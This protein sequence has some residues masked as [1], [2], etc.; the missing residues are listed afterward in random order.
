MHIFL[1]FTLDGG[2]FPKPYPSPPPPPQDKMTLHIEQD[3]AWAPEP[4]WMIL[5]GGKSLAAV[6][7]H[8][9]YTNY[10]ILAPILYTGYYKLSL[11]M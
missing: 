8:S 7:K 1:T 9:H 4:V 11:L 5:R 10:A 6:N 3:A 2:K